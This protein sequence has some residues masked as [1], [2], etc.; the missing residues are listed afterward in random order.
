MLI[1]FLSSALLFSVFPDIRHLNLLKFP[2][3]EEPRDRGPQNLVGIP[4]QLLGENAADWHHLCAL[5]VNSAAQPS[6]S[7]VLSQAR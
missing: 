6:R 1:V 2:R 7:C 4:R 5:K 3:N